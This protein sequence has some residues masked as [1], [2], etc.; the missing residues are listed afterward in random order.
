[1]KTAQVIYGVTGKEYLNVYFFITT[2]YKTTACVR[3][4]GQQNGFG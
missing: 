2:I 3:V 1:M 4:A